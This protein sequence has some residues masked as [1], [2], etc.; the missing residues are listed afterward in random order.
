MAW[1]DAT[2]TPQHRWSPHLRG[3]LLLFDGRPAPAYA[4]RVGV[5]LLLAAAFL[6]VLRLG[7]V[8][9]LYPPIPLVLLMAVL[10]GFGLLAV[11]RV[12]GIG[13]SHRGFRPWR[14][15]TATEKSYL[16]QA[17]APTST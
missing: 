4:P 10:L 6:E 5:R 3:H 12:A 7:A 15:W 1:V 2:I 14:D 17:S 11:P 16:L 13:L 9:W 8:R